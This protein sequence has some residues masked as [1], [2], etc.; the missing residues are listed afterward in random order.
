[1]INGYKLF[2]R[3]R[4]CRGV[5]V[6]CSINEN[7]S[8]KTGNVEGIVK[9]SEIIL[10]EFS[11]RTRKWLF[12]GLYKPPSQ[13]EHSFLNDLSLVINRLICQYENL[14]LIGDFNMTIENE[15]LEFF[16]NSFGLECLIKNQHVSS[17]KIQVVVTLF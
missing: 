2:R 9:E 16:M 13:I 4:N 11:I 12:I 7:I 15:N 14:M 1:M 6:L 10:I 3:H 5:G 17:L 8:P